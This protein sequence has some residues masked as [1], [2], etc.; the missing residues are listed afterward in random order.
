M[1]EFSRLRNVQ[2]RKIAAEADKEHFRGG[3][4]SESRERAERKEEHPRKFEQ[5]EIPEQCPQPPCHGFGAAQN[6]F[7]RG[8][9]P[10]GRSRAAENQ[11]GGIAHRLRAPVP[12][13]EIGNRNP[14]RQGF[15]AV[16]QKTE[17]VVANHAERRRAEQLSVVGAVAQQ[18][19]RPLVFL[20]LFQVFGHKIPI[21]ARRNADCRAVVLFKR[22]RLFDRKIGTA[23]A[24]VPQAVLAG[25]R[26]KNRDLHARPVQLVQPFVQ[27]GQEYLS[28]CKQTDEQK[29]PVLLFDHSPHTA[30]RV[31]LA[32]AEPQDALQPLRSH[33][34]LAALGLN[35]GTAR[36]RANAVRDVQAEGLG[37]SGNVQQLFVARRNQVHGRKTDI[38]RVQ[39]EF[40]CPQQLGK[41]GH[42]LGF[43][44]AVALRGGKRLA[45]LCKQNKGF[46]K[47]RKRR[48]ARYHTVPRI[49]C[50]QMQSAVR[51][52]GAVGNHKIGQIRKGF[53]CNVGS[54]VN[55]IPFLLFRPRRAAIPKE[56]CG[57]VQPGHADRCRRGDN[58]DRQ[59]NA[60]RGVRRRRREQ[61]HNA[62]QKQEQKRSEGQQ[63]AVRQNAAEH[64]S[65]D[66]SCSLS[67]AFAHR[68]EK[69]GLPQLDRERNGTARNDFRAAVYHIFEIWRLRG[70]TER[71]ETVGGFAVEMRGRLLPLAPCHAHGQV[72]AREQP[73]VARDDI[74]F[75]KHDD[76]AAYHARGG[77]QEGFS[78]PQNRDRRRAEKGKIRLEAPDCVQQPPEEQ[79]APYAEQEQE[80][81]TAQKFVEAQRQNPAQQGQQ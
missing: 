12:H 5:R 62:D 18:C 59:E 76:V 79:S 26:Q 80:R 63:L 50:A 15:P 8:D 47:P 14:L 57:K 49:A 81:Q 27:V 48:A 71:I 58:A 6:R 51:E 54:D 19:R 33:G 40:A 42:V 46:G 52:G 11:I 23:V 45:C 67:E 73:A 56:Q 21:R 61:R 37:R 25:M 36:D 24:E 77:D 78:L 55:A 32:R 53:V 10:A 70:V 29:P 60:Q 20:Q 39:V 38:Q 66:R 1:L 28:E 2:R 69:G 75:V 74:P 9:S 35:R 13:R 41:I 4:R 34:K 3:R 68:A 44:K 72:V 7:K 65:S 31:L 22:R 30:R 16:A 43:G 17:A 64:L